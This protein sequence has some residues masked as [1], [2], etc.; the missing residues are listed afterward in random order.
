MLHLSEDTLCYSRCMVGGFLLR[1]VQASS[2]NRPSR[3]APP[4][5]TLT[6]ACATTAALLPTEIACFNQMVRVCVVF[7]VRTPFCCLVCVVSLY[8]LLVGL[9]GDHYRAGSLSARG[10][11]T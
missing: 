11:T 3:S 6:G 2:A 7:A 5:Y 8:T 9:G 10:F 4:R 1:L